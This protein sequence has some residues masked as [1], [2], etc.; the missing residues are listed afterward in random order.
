MMVNCARCVSVKLNVAFAE[1]QDRARAGHL[2]MA[3]DERCSADHAKGFGAD[4]GEGVGLGLGAG[5]GLGVGAGIGEGVGSRGGA[6]TSHVVAPETTTT[7]VCDP[8][9]KPVRLADPESQAVVTPSS[10]QVVPLLSPPTVNATLPEVLVESAG[11]AAVIVTIGAGGVTTNVADAES[12]PPGPDAVTTNVCEPTL[13][14]VKLADSESQAAFT[15]SSVQA[16]PLLSPPTTNATLPTVLG[17]SVGG[18]EVIVTVGAGGVTTNVA[19]SAAE[20]L[21]PVT[22]TTNVCEPTPR[23]G[24]LAEPESHAVLAPS[25]VH[26]VSVIAPLTVNVTLP[27]VLGELGGGTLVM[28]TVGAGGGGGGGRDLPGGGRGVG[29]AG[30]GDSDHDRVR[31]HAQVGEASGPRVTRFARTIQCARD[32]GNGAADGEQHTTGGARSGGL[33]VRR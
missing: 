4:V 32:A 17:E 28:V 13:K 31:A 12:E 21:G 24:K 29:A 2:E 6:V 16:V 22:V 25:R 9:L 3:L 33:G 10:V 26:V 8:T 1:A 20:P 19:D 23:S 11:G 27:A 14:P 7:N 5:V 30:A 15:S 18:A